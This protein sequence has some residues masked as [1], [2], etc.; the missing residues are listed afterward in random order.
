MME[1]N[2]QP[3]KSNWISGM[4]EDG[5]TLLDVIGRITSRRAE[6]D[7]LG[8]SPGSGGPYELTQEDFNG[9]NSHLTPA[10]MAD[11]LSSLDVLKAPLAEG[12]M[13]NLAKLRR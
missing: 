10:I 9:T 13:T 5:T 8:M 1:Q 12:H 3:K 6:Y 4:V 7:A 11:A 2:I